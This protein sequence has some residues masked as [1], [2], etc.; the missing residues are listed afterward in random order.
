MTDSA[1]AHNLMTFLAVGTR[2]KAS[3]TGTDLLSGGMPCYSTYHTV[4]DRLI[5]VDAPELE[6]WQVTCDVTGKPARKDNH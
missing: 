4:D 6:F 1:F 2:G 3:P 5:T